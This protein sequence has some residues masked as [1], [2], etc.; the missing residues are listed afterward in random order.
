M[1]VDLICHCH[2]GMCELCCVIILSSIL[3]TTHETLSSP[4][5]AFASGLTNVLISL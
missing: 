5:V 3:V 1:N 4:S 2:C